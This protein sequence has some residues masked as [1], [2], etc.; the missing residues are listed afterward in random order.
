MIPNI[1]ILMASGSCETASKLGGDGR[2]SPL[3]IV[4][5]QS[6]MK[7]AV[8]DGVVDLKANGFLDARHHNLIV[9]WCLYITKITLNDSRRG[10][11]PGSGYSEAAIHL[12]CAAFHI[13]DVI[14]HWD[15]LIL[16]IVD[17]DGFF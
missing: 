12:N 10:P 2:G 4:C 5:F 17:Y 13:D 7:R 8:V 9:P 14:G 3:E 1:L 16:V 15:R 11:I 6:I